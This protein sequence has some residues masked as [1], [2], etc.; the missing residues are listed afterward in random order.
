MFMDGS[1]TRRGRLV[2]AIA[3]ADDTRDRLLEAAGR[4]F[5]EQGFYA[6][7]IRDICA[8]AGA[9]VASVN[10]HFRDKL[11]LYI[12]ALRKLLPKAG[13]H[14]QPSA[15]QIKDPEQAFRMFVSQMLQRMSEAASG[16]SH[17]RI[18]AQE[19]VRPTPAL[20]QAVEEMI[21]PNYET[22]RGLIGRILHLPPDHDTTRLCAHSVIGQI[23]HY[24]HARPVI[25]LLWPDL[26]FTPERL[27][28]IAEHIA[29][30]TLCSM[31]TIAKGKKR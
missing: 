4:V 28:Q 31:K 15:R 12:E 9:N 27:E 21:R 2:P 7:T 29:S 11:T 8:G 20:P 23:T 30:L 14:E 6:A 10:Y 25:E 13:C 19:M 26:R 1:N 3:E 17:F 24:V 22:L 18:M 16:A 5:A